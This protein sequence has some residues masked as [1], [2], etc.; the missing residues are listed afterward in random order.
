MTKEW[1]IIEFPHTEGPAA[2][3]K[4]A[5]SYKGR[6][7]PVQGQI[8]RSK[9]FRLPNGRIPKQNDMILCGSCCLPVRPLTAWGASWAAT[10]AEGWG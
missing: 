9:D 1:V 8:I 10:T 4:L 2:C 5:F 3:G 7:P 6:K